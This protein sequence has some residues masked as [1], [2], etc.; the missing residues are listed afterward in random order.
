MK[1][2]LTKYGQ[3][4]FLF[5]FVLY[6]FLVAYHLFFGD[7][8]VNYGF[9]YAITRGEV[10]YVDYNLIIPLFSPLLYSIVL[11]FSKS[12]LFY[13]IIQAVFVVLLFIVISKMLKEKWCLLLPVVF[14]G[15]PIAVVTILFPG[16]NFI[17]LFLL[18]IVIYCELQEKNDYLIGFLLGLMFLTKHTLGIVF[19]LPSLFY[20]RTPKKIIKRFLGWLFPILIFIVYL[21]ISKSF[22]EFINL[23]ILGIFD[24]A[25]KNG[26]LMEWWLIIPFVICIGYVFYCIFKK[27]HEIIPYYILLSCF[28]IFPLF[29]SYHLSFFLFTTMFLFLYYHDIS[30]PH[31][32]RYVFIFLLFLGIAWTF[33]TFQFRDGEYSFYSYPNYPLRYFSKRDKK[34]Y[35]D[36]DN[37]IKDWNG[38]VVLF[39]LGTENY[40]YKITNNLDI[41]YFDLPNYGNYGYHGMKSMLKKFKTL[42]S[43][44]VILVDEWAMND[45]AY[46]QQYYKELAQYVVEHYK[47]IGQVGKYSAYLKEE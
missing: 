7:T 3:F 22:S 42:K 5:F 26:T 33:I 24:F 45:D 20:W 18:F 38:E 46:N 47:N 34:N 29:D 21:I 28:Y 1:K 15:F 41:T 17:L 39:G 36:V 37:F 31:L 30:I 12:F 9:S 14:L 8:I 19:V 35:E 40:F 32:F 43:H 25:G 10:P 44:T 23:C 4:I 11:F 2:K 16:Y 13:Y 6:G 27:K